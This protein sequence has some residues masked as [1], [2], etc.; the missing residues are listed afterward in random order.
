MVAR[1]SEPLT[2]EQQCR[3]K[4]NPETGHGSPSALNLEPAEVHSTAHSMGRVDAVRNVWRLESAQVIGSVL[5][6]V[7]SSAHTVLPGVA[8][9]GAVPQR[10]ASRATSSSPR[11]DS[12]SPDAS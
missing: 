8:G 7:M 12:A 6:R 10:V 1:V 9:R 3:P 11:P 2:T 4:P 5:Q